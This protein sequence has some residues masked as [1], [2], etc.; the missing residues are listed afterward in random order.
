[1]G[2]LKWDTDTNK[3][4]ILAKRTCERKP[5]YLV[6]KAIRLHDL[7]IGDVYYFTS[8]AW[9]LGGAFWDRNGDKQRHQVYHYFGGGSVVVT[10]DMIVEMQPYAYS[11]KKEELLTAASIIDNKYF[12]YFDDGYYVLETESPFVK[13]IKGRIVRTHTCLPIEWE[14]TEDTYGYR[15]YSINANLF[16]YVKKSN[17]VEK[18][19]VN[20]YTH[21]INIRHDKHKRYLKKCRYGIISNDRSIYYIQKRSRYRHSFNKKYCYKSTVFSKERFFSKG[22]QDGS[23]VMF[24]CFSVI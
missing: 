8:N 4:F 7:R 20:H 5:R 15:L 1:M 14:F 2:T 9:I 12:H 23:D 10:K 21:D 6:N 22:S 16:K 18:T 11:E 17:G 3:W 13:I 24:P 19:T